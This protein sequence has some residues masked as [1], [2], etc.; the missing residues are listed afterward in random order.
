MTPMRLSDHPE[1]VAL[2][3]LLGLFSAVRSLNAGSESD[4]MIKA[5]GA[6]QTN[7]ILAP[8]DNST[9]ISSWATESEMQRR[10]DQ[11]IASI[12][13]ALSIITPRAYRWLVPVYVLQISR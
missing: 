2:G 9:E 1:R 10:D 12:A 8:P 6:T 7:S 3:I 11:Q 5:P 4:P 13:L